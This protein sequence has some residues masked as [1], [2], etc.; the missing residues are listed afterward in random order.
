M[1]SKASPIPKATRSSHAAK[2]SG[3]A[4]ADGAV[5][6][7]RSKPS[8]P[9]ID[10]TS[11]DKTAKVQAALYEIASAA[12]AVPD[13]QEFYASMDRIIGELMYA[14]NFFIALYDEPSGLLSFPYYV[15]EEDEEPPTQPL[16]NFLGATG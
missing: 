6:S 4:Q 15:D 13:M 11:A 14:K 8:A 10:Q 9:S 3:P 12:S 2:Q 5:R 1:Q 16:V 7:R